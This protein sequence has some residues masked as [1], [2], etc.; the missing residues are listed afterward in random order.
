M[1]IDPA[2]GAESDCNAQNQRCAIAL[3]PIADEPGTAH[4]GAITYGKALGLSGIGNL[5]VIHLAPTGRPGQTSLTMSNALVTDV[6]AQR[7]HTRSGR[8]R[9]DDQ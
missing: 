6:S 8:R 7:D 4:L 2:F 1:T 3:G 9:P 5:A